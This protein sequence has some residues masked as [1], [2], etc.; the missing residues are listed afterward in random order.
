M[1]MTCHE[2]VGNR[3]VNQSASE[4]WVSEISPHL[5]MFFSQAVLEVDYKTTLTFCSYLKSMLLPNF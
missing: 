4:V 5:I 3:C 1:I 2:N